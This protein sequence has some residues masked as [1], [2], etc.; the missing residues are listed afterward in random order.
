LPEYPTD[1]GPQVPLAVAPSDC[2]HVSH[3]PLH[4]LLQQYPLTQSPFAQS[5]LPLGHA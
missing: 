5:L 1:A 3:A 2:A 4:A